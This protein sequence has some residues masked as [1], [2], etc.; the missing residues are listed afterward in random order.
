MGCGMVLYCTGITALD[1]MC[2]CA[3]IVFQKKK[4]GNHMHWDTCVCAMYCIALELTA[5]GT[6]VCVQCI[7]FHWNHSTG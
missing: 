5:R 6:I 2:V 1:K 3:C 7:V 4:T